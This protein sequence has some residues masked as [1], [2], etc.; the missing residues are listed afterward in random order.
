MKINFLSFLFYEAVRKVSL[1]FFTGFFLPLNCSTH[2]CSASFRAVSRLHF[3]V[4]VQGARAFH[5]HLKQIALKIHTPSTK[6]FVISKPET[7]VFDE[8]ILGTA[9]SSTGWCHC[10][11]ACEIFSHASICFFKGPSYTVAQTPSGFSL[12]GLL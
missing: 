2:P 3:P 12:R 11:T 5:L 10:S 9:N 1:L 7:A 8:L 4:P 6:S